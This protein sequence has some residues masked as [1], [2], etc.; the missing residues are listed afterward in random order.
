MPDMVTFIYPFGS[1]F[2]TMDHE[3]TIV[4]CGCGVCYEREERVLPIKDIGIFDCDECGQ[5]I[6][7][8]SGRK[9]PVFKRIRTEATQERSA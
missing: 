1:M 2:A 9:V 5:R 7:I 4:T 8:W 3:R 6:E